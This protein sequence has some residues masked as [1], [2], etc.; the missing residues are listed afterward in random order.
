MN[1][2]ARELKKLKIVKRGRV[3]LKSGEVSDFYVDMKKAFGDPRAFSLICS[4]LC[5]IIDKR[6]TCVAGSGHGGL[7]LATAVSLR[8]KL[9]LVLVRDSDKKHGLSKLIDGY[10]PGKKDKVVVI[11]D[12]FS[13]GTSI[14]NTVRALNKTK[15]KI[16]AGYVVVSRGDASNFKIS[17]NSL[18]DHRKL[19]N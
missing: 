6:A 18:L 5:K 1:L 14:S 12:V 7:P 17:I 8:L 3:V 9:P 4:E 15:S 2:L 16:V 10:V 13:S 11:D 19:L